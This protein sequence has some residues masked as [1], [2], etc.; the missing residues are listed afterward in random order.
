[1]LRTLLPGIPQRYAFAGSAIGVCLPLL[2]FTLESLV[3]HGGATVWSRLSEP[4]HAVMAF[5]PIIFGLVFYRIGIG[6]ADLALKL[7]AKERSER[8][9]RQFSLSDRLTGLP[10]RVALEIEIARFIEAGRKG[11]FHPALLLMDLDRFKNVNDTLGHD[12][13]DL[14]LKEFGDRIS[15]T[16]GPLARLFR[17]GGDEFVISVAGRPEPEDL[18]RLCGMIEREA[19]KPYDLPNGKAQTGISIG[20]AFVEA[21]D[22]AMNAVMKRADLALYSAKELQ[23]PSHVYYSPALA[24]NVEQQM[25]LEQEIASALANDE[26][27]TEYQPIVSAGDRELKAFEALVRWQ[28]PT[29]GLLL[30]DQFLALAEKTGHILALGRKVVARAIEDAS[31]WPAHIGVAVNVS[32]NEFRDPNFARYVGQCLSRCKVEPYRLTIEITESIFTIDIETVTGAL[33]ELRAI[34]I[35]IA[36]DDFGSGFSSINHLRSFPIDKLKI[37]RSFTR[38]LFESGRG[39]ELVDIILKLGRAFDIP[40]TVEGVETEDQIDLVRALGA[41]DVQGYLISKP[42]PANVIAAMLSTANTAGHG[43]PFRISA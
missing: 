3:Q 37:D 29:R 26:F 4:T 40:A 16:I 24:N 22:L 35:K 33:E 32:G 27:I 38:A 17:L 14:L 20:I 34:G 12:T 15:R 25:R 6:R 9:L 8:R 43:Q 18:E 23:G 1:M 7:K 19:F 41:A 39:V 10:N 21:E 13:G 2:S 42:M 28:H 30:P 5:M 31:R 36:L 11:A